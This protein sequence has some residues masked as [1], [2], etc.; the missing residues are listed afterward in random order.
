LGQTSLLVYWVHIEFVYGR[1]SLLPKRAE[2]I[3]DASRG[4]LEIFVFMLLLSLIRTRIDW[5]RIDWKK[6]VMSWKKI[7]GGVQ[8]A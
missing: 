6:R 8:P 4:L 3:L 1:F 5:K 2:S 7:S